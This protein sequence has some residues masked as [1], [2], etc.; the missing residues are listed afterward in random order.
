MDQATISEV[1]LFLKESLIQYGIR[2]ESIALFGSALAGDMNEDSDIDL[3]V[4]SP[5]FAKLDLFER[6]KMTMKPEIL[7]L[8]K[9]RISMDIINLSP[10]EYETSN[11]R[12][13]YKSKIVA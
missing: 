4:I 9:Y 13:F 8:K 10:E 6:A 5:D 2:V 11:I 12:L 7:T 1:I 3:I